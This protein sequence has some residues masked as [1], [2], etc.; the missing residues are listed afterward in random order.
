M[1]LL[2]LRSLTL[3][4]LL[5]IVEVATPA[6]T[7]QEPPSKNAGAPQNTWGGDHIELVMTDTGASLEFD[8]AS[9]A[10]GKPIKVDAAGA[11]SVKGTLSRE[12][13]GPT[14]RDEKSNGDDVIYSGRI[15]DDTMHLKMTSRAD[16]RIDESYT[17]VRGHYGRLT[18]CK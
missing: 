11:F 3:L 18:K 13:P 6:S 12:R 16:D 7:T 1:R 15:D 8:C 14:T 4:F 5:A 10:M 2:R 9:G 17:L